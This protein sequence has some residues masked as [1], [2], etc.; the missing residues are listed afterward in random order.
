MGS[1]CRERLGPQDLGH[2][3]EQLEEQSSNVN[4]RLGLPTGDAY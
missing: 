3:S 2:C 1:G 4:G